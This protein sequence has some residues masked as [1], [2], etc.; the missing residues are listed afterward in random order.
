ME[1]NVQE[2]EDFA[3]FNVELFNESVVALM[4][5]GQKYLTVRRDGQIFASGETSEDATKLLQGCKLGV[6][7]VILVFNVV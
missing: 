1:A 3:Y 6:C 2:L 4:S 7:A 5:A